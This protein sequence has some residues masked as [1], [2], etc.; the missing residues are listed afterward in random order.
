MRVIRTPVYELSLY[1]L[2]KAYGDQQRRQQAPSLEIA[3]TEY[4]TVD[5]ALERLSGLLGRMPDWQKLESF[6]PSDL[7]GPDMVRSAIAATFAATLELAKV[8][9]LTLRQSG[10]FGP[11][12]LRAVKE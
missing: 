10:I 4:Y 2:L 11:I 5:E 12:Y 3:P 9:K 8:G 7:Q 1:D 6:L